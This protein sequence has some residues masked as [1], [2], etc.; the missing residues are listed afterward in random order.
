[1]EKNEK[2]KPKPDHFKNIKL[3]YIYIY[4]YEE[5]IEVSKLCELYMIYGNIVIKTIV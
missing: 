4:I 1:M 2:K 3:Y 5:W